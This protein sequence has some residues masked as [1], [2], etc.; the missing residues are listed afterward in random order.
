MHF[1]TIFNEVSGTLIQELDTP[2]G[3]RIITF[4]SKQQGIGKSETGQYHAHSALSKEQI[5]A[6]KEK[7]QYFRSLQCRTVETD[8]LKQ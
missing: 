5:E 4:T 7:G 8:L 3:R 6:Y 1:T 2:A